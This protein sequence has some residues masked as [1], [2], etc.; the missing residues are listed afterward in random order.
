MINNNTILYNY[1]A[2]SFLFPVIII[3]YL[4]SALME[5]CYN[6]VRILINAQT[7][8]RLRTDFTS[9]LCRVTLI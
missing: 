4:F 5:S 7:L 9:S 8:H 3:P 1:V 2:L 6:E